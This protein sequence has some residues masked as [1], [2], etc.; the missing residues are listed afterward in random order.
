MVRA[1]I[2]EFYFPF[3]L[4]AVVGRIMSPFHPGHIH[5]LIPRTYE[6][7][8]LSDQSNLANIIKFIVNFAVDLKIRKS[9]WIMRVSPIKS[10]KPLKAE[11]FLQLEAEEICNKRE[12][13]R[14]AAEAG[15]GICLLSLLKLYYRE[16]S[17]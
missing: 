8:T 16:P 15:V 10:H 13:K 2:P 11:N 1:S 3:W 4:T 5:A 17:Y 12:S 14:A 7:T 9:S 6:Y